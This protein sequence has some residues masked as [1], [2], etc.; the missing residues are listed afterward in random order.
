VVG[1]VWATSALPESASETAAAT[2]MIN[3]MIIPVLTRVHLLH[4]RAD[5]TPDFGTP[6]PDSGDDAHH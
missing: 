4:W 2:M 6:V 3:L 1:R 5:G